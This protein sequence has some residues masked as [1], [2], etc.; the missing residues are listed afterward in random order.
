MGR[1]PEQRG[2]RRA[3]AR[4]LARRLHHE[5]PRKIGRLGRHHRLRPDRRRSLRRG[6]F[7]H[8]ARYRT[9][10]SAPRRHLSTKATPARPI[11]RRRGRA[12]SLLSFRTKPTSAANQPSSQLPLQGALA[13]RTGRRTAQTRPTALRKDSPELQINRKFRRMPVLDQIH[14]HGLVAIALTSRARS[15]SRRVFTSE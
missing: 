15:H 8:P 1:P 9:R 11:V 14:P 10:H 4:S 12:A 2:A 13:H 3:S 6:S 5:N 7:R